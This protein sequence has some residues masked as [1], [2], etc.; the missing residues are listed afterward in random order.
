MRKG[1]EVH[2]MIVRNGAVLETVK[3]DRQLMEWKRSRVVVIKTWDGNSIGELV[4]VVAAVELT[5]LPPDQNCVDWCRL[6]VEELMSRGFLDGRD[7]K[8]FRELISNCEE[9]RTR[10]SGVFD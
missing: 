8:E 10:T 9:I 4:D 2:A 6:A 7:I 5:R 3:Q 1:F